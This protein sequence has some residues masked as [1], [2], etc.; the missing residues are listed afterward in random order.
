MQLLVLA[1]GLGLL[2]V[3][4]AEGPGFTSARSDEE[5]GAVAAPAEISRAV[6]VQDRLPLLNRRICMSKGDGGGTEDKGKS[7]SCTENG[8][9]CR[10]LE[11]A[12]QALSHCPIHPWQSP[13]L[14]VLGKRARRCGGDGQGKGSGHAPQQAI[15]L[16][17]ILPAA[18]CT[19]HLQ[20]QNWLQHRAYYNLKSQIQLQTWPRT[21]TWRWSQASFFTD[22]GAAF[23]HS[24]GAGPAPPSAQQQLWS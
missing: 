6:S 17:R 15:S 11:R 20:L 12:F 8:L 16:A 5:V 1:A 2:S 7:P 19:Y 10:Y 23:S 4:G 24:S 18:V 14:R 3:L 21:H 9:Q 22:R 13:V